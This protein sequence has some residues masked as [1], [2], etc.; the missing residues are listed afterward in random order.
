M[1]KSIWYTKGLCEYLSS[2]G[3]K[4]FATGHGMSE[5]YQEGVAFMFNTESKSF[6]LKDFVSNDSAEEASSLRNEFREEGEIKIIE[7]CAKL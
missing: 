7:E 3:F 1:N 4:H 5:D 2:K 6:G